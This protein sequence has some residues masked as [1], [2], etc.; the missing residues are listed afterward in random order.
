M[1]FMRCSIMGK[2]YGEDLEA[3]E[4][5]DHEKTKDDF[6]VPTEHEVEEAEE[7]PEVLVCRTVLGSSTDGCPIWRLITLLSP[8]AG[9]HFQ[10]S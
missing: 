3:V 2:A 5:G 9:V 7:R 6:K 8:L 1:F 4:D 10:G